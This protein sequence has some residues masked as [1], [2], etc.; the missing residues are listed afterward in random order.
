MESKEVIVLKKYICIFFIVFVLVLVPVSARAG[1]GH[2]S[3]GS[4]GGST[5]RHYG[6][7]TSAS[8]ISTIVAVVS[9]IGI[10]V[11]SMTKIIK[12]R[13]ES[14]KALDEA[15]AY[16][17]FWVED[18]LIEKV[19]DSYFAIQN[20]WTHQDLTT[21]S[22]YLTQDLYEKWKSKITFQQLRNEKNVLENIQLLN[23][24]IIEVHD[25]LDNTKDYFWVMIKGKMKDSIE[26]N[27]EVISVDYESFKEYWKFVRY[28]NRILLDEVLQEDEMDLIG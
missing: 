7:A 21:L 26:Q 3:G 24:S 2:S 10:S 18:E 23:K 6:H 20:A 16:D 8:P 19:K 13:I 15:S 4:R 9:G 5:R 25:D 12:K 1:G 14:K 22:Y 27:G 28:G 17:L 11:F